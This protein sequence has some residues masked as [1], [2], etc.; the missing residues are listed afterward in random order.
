MVNIKKIKGLRNRLQNQK[1]FLQKSTSKTNII[2]LFFLKENSKEKPD[3]KRKYGKIKNKC[4]NKK[5]K[6]G[7]I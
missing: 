4:F 6:R 1:V 5:G 2:I 7:D 3:K